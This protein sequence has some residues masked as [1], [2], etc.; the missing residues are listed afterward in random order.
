MKPGNWILLILGAAVLMSFTTMAYKTILKSFLPSVE[1]FNT[2][3][4]WD[5]NRWSW[6]YGT[7]VPGSK[8][9][10][11]IVPQKTITREQAFT[12]MMIHIEADKEYLQRFLKVD[13]NSNQWAALLSFSYNLGS[14][15]ADNLIPNI[16]SKNVA[17]LQTQW[18]KYV[19]AGGAQLQF[20][21]ERRKKEWDLY[22]TV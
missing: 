3:P 10:P 11:D 15:N 7:R 14:R 16:N 5:V 22:T 20:L 12:D 8:D 13:L 6:G 2:K 9:D 17:A 4:Y 19:Y 18:K 1:G 21:V